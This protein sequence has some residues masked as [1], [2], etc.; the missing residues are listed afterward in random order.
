MPL[1]MTQWSYTREALAALVKKPENRREVFR[2][3]VERLGGRMIAWY[4]CRGDYD[5]L[6]IYEVPDE[7][8]AT[9][10]LLAL[11]EPGHLK[12]TKTTSLHTAEEGVEAMHRAGKQTLLPPGG[13]RFFPGLSST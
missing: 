10:L 9:T 3:H 1:Y 2:E 12:E 6:T 4:H 7:L 11:N 5:G 8:T 13:V